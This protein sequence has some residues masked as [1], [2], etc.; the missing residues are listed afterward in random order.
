VPLTATSLCLLTRVAGDGGRQ[1]LLGHKKT[2]LGSGKIVGLGGHVE[3]SESPAEAAAREVKEESGLHVTPDALQEIA[4]VTFLF[5]VCPRWDMT[6][7][8]FTSADWTGDAAETPEIR[9]EW[10]AVTDLP[11]TRMWDDARYWLPRV[12]AGERIKATFSYAADCETVASAAIGTL[13]P[14]S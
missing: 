1:V 13:P 8:V 4:Y 6:V 7:S 2:G 12:L 10:F 5:P 11:L 9:P 3:D 14:W